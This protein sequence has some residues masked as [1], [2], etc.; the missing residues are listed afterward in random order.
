MART[1]HSN[2]DIKRT[3]ETH[4]I[5]KLGTP[6]ADLFPSCSAPQGRKMDFVTHYA[7]SQSID[8]LPHGYKLGIT[9]TII[10]ISQLASQVRYKLQQ[11]LLP[12]KRREE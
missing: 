6:A 2:R 8:R 5:C 12:D 4:L 1:E 9:S 11:V 3:C 10:L 7:Q